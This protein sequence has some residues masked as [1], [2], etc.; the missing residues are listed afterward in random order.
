ML[1]EARDCFLAEKGFIVEGYAAPT[2]RVKL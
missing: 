1:R 2:Y